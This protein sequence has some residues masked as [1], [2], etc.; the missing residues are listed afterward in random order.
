MEVLTLLSNKD[1]LK[2]SLKLI[3]PVNLV[4]Y[5]T[6]GVTFYIVTLSKQFSKVPSNNR[7]ETYQVVIPVFIGIATMFYI[8]KKLKGFKKKDEPVAKQE[9]NF[10]YDK[11]NQNPDYTEPFRA[12]NGGF[13]FTKENGTEEITVVG[14]T[15]T[16]KYSF[17]RMIKQ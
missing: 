8:R 9:N 16:R 3:R 12:V 5:L 10:D 7:I 15:T 14:N 17:E 13:T 11:Y 2:H 6:G 4:G 1:I